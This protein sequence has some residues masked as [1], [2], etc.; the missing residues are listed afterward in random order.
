MTT[1]LEHNASHPLADSRHR[2][3]SPDGGGYESYYLK[4]ANPDGDTSVWVRHT[5][6]QA[7]GGQPRGSLW[8]TLF[9]R[10]AA[11]PYAVKQ[12]FEEVVAPPEGG[13]LLAIGEA[14]FGLGSVS[15]EA[16][17]EGRSASWRLE[18][19]GGAEPLL[20]LPERLYSAPLPRTKSLTLVPEAVFDGSLGIADR[21]IDIRGWHGMVGHNWGS[22]HAEQ[23]VWLYGDA[24]APG[25]VQ[26]EPPQAWL[27]LVA[28]RVRV[29][30]VTAPWI[31]NGCLKLGG[32]RIP[33]GGIGRTASTRV[34]PRVGRCTVLLRGDGVRARALF[35]ASRDQ[36]VAWR[37]ADP[38]GSEHHVL[39]SSLANLELTVERKHHAP[40]VL[41][42]RGRAVYEWGTRYTAHGIPLEPFGD[43]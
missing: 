6:H 17:G 14:V 40:Q 20:H 43:G 22:Q 30:P 15:G 42:A 13:G 7:P 16:R 35:T 37:Y 21:Q 25:G 19:S 29:G 5:V 23:W 8:C 36:L 41:R 2:R 26:G 31:A 3:F 27:D 11:R 28:G 10:G 39:N 33:V 18:L 9:E 24:L 32:E 38:D 1:L 34:R 12:T 4:A